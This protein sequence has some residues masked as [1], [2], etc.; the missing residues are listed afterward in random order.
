MLL[1]ILRMNVCVVLLPNARVGLMREQRPMRLLRYPPPS[2]SNAFHLNSHRNRRL[3][4]PQHAGCKG[5]FSPY[6]Y[7]ILENAVSPPD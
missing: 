7:P 1:P 3:V 2:P 4:L 5:Q 6:C